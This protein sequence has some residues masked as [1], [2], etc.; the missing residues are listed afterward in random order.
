MKKFRKK[1]EQQKIKAILFSFLNIFS[2]Q[3]QKKKSIHGSIIYP[4]TDFFFT[5]YIYLLSLYTL[6][7]EYIKKT[8]YKYFSN[9]L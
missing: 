5:S 1:Y 7:V 6:P 4:V 2:K 8:F 9:T 3:N